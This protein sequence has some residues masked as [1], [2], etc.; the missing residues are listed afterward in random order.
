MQFG[1]SIPGYDIRVL[2]E[3]QVRAAAG[4]LFV[5]AF[6]AFLNAFLVGEYTLLKIFVV[7]FWSDF[8]IR[9]FINTRYSPSLILGL[10]AVRKQKPEYAGA[11]QKRFAW[12]L[13]FGMATIMILLLF[14]LDI[15]GP[16]NFAFCIVCL[17]LLFF[18]NCFWD[19][20][21]VRFVYHD[22]W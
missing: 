14:V 5:F 19:L 3:R 4:L 13:G 17:I 9:V 6:T 10:L 7:F 2:N 15:R 8:A 21:W 16:I 11:P 12:M 20:C 1:E 22:F 18:R